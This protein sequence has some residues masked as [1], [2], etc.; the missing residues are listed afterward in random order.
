MAGRLPGRGM[1]PAYLHASSMSIL[2]DM[3]P[4]YGHAG[5]MSSINDIQFMK[6]CSAMASEIANIYQ[7]VVHIDEMQQK[8]Y[9]TTPTEIQFI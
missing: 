1:L 2:I 3:L 6:V 8:I 4:A 9:A 7:F 5:S